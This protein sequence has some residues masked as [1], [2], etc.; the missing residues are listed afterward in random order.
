METNM[1]TNDLSPLR[2][3]AE[4]ASMGDSLALSPLAGSPD[5]R[6]GGVAR[7]RP[8]ARRRCAAHTLVQK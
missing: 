2:D 6:H 5:D 4:H 7:A 1:E 3:G 8:R